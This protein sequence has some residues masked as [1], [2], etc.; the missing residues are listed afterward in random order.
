MST[1]NHILRDFATVGNDMLH[2][3]L[4][5][6]IGSHSILAGDCS[7]LA[8]LKVGCL[9]CLAFVLQSDFEVLSLKIFG[10]HCRIFSDFRKYFKICSEHLKGL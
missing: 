10:W 5:L 3:Y 4:H 2:I 9:L 7:E 8:G 1:T 6:F